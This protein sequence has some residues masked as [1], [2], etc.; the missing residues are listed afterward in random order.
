MSRIAGRIGLMVEYELH[1]LRSNLELNIR[2]PS[3]IL[4]HTALLLTCLLIGVSLALAPEYFLLEEYPQVLVRSQEI[5]NNILT[6]LFALLLLYTVMRSLF[7]QGLRVYVA[8]VDFDVMVLTPIDSRS[9]VT[10]KCVRSLVSRL[11]L[12]LLAF[13]I[14]APIALTIKT[15]LIMLVAAVASLTLYFEFLQALSYAFHAVKDAFSSKL[16]SLVKLAIKIIGIG[17]LAIITLIITLSNYLPI[18]SFSTVLA[19]GMETFW[20]LLPS[21]LTASM[22]IEFMLGHSEQAATWLLYLSSFLIGA[23]TLMFVASGPYHPEEYAP[24]QIHSYHINSLG[25]RIGR[26]FEKRLSWERPSRLVFF[27]DIQLAL[28]GALVDFSL[29]NFTVM[30]AVSLGS[31]YLLISFFPLQAIPD[32]EAKLGP[33]RIFIRD[34]VIILALLPFIPSLTSF[35]RELTKIWLLK[36]FPLKNREVSNG[37]FLFALTVSTVSLI[38]MVLVA[39]LALEIP[40]TEWMIGILLLL[41]I[42]IANAFGVLVGAYMPPYDLGN[43]M[44]LKA[45]STY[46]ML[47]VV[48]LSPFTLITSARDIVTQMFLLTLLTLYSIVTTIYFLREAGKG[49]EKLE[50]RVILPRK[51]QGIQRGSGEVSIAERN[52]SD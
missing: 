37:K 12:V 1:M 51:G 31:W 5:L 46:F 15:P 49:F 18:E 35:S 27:K 11:S 28:R 44:S 23:L 20:N 34:L 29:L 9:I 3:Y 41:I 52:P 17:F 42:P 43:E 26:L 36:V 14:I 48:V 4:S 13:F 6:T 24:R 8:S 10:G 50:L 25:A 2:K 7:S 38:P 19:S 45:I 21:S 40:S 32:F 47:L 16:S 22:I 33:L 30:Y 39:G